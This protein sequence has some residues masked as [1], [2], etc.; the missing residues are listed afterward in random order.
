M[1]AGEVRGRRLADV[2][3]E[4]AL[5]VLAAGQRGWCA[6]VSTAFLATEQHVSVSS[7]R[8]WAGASKSN[9]TA[10]FAQVSRA[11]AGN[12][13]EETGTATTAATVPRLA[14]HPQVPRRHQLVEQ[15]RGLLHHPYG[16]G[17]R[18]DATLRVLR[19]CLVG[20]IPFD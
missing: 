7:S 10:S 12:R 1:L 6:R 9:A 5:R 14:V 20:L 2:R 18:D 19:S 17:R 11:E 3:E 15:R 4:Q 16:V 8:R 13:V